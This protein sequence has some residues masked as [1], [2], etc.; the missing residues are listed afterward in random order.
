M[1]HLADLY[2][3]DLVWLHGVS[4]MIVSDRDPRFTTRLWQCLQSA[5]GTMLTL[6]TA[7]HPPTDGQSERTIQILED[8]LRGCVL[9][10]RG[11]WERHMHW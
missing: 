7:Y 4:V 3:R 9:N 2:F 5:F 1:D 8:M 11:T 6:C 10:F